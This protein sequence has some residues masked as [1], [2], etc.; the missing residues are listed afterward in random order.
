V[1]ATDLAVV[2]RAALAGDDGL[3]ARL[4]ADSRPDLDLLPADVR[5]TL[6]DVQVRAQQAQYAQTYPRARHEIVVAGGKDVGRIIIDA[7]EDETRVVD[8]VVAREH[9]GRG[10]ASAVLNDVLGEAERL[11]SPVTLS[12]WRTNLPA[13]HLYERLGFVSI[14][15]DDTRVEMR[16]APQHTKDRA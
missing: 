1:L 2:R 6:L 3:V 14:D 15:A 4:F 7:A 8:L 13:L 9:R 10:I 11:G 16:R 5:G 12:V